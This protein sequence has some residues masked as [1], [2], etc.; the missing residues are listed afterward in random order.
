MKTI[1]KYT[2]RKH[3]VGERVNHAHRRGRPPKVQTPAIASASQQGG[4]AQAPGWGKT[5]PETIRI[6]GVMAK[7]PEPITAPALAQAA[8]VYLK[9]ASNVL[10]QL[11]GKG[12]LERVSHGHFT[13]TKLFG[14]AATKP[15]AGA[16]VSQKESDW[17]KLRGE[18]SVPRDPEA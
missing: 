12:K 8:V 7:M 10:T 4:R 16:G 15:P 13:R 3:P 18:I 11:Y 17:Q 9:K 1:R 5:H 2:P 6:M 14:L